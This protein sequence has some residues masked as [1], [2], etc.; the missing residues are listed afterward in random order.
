M[1]DL[2]RVIGIWVENRE[3]YPNTV[4][5][6][7]QAVLAAQNENAPEVFG[8]KS[9]PKPPEFRKAYPE[10]PLEEDLTEQRDIIIERVARPLGLNIDNTL[11]ELSFEFPQRGSFYDNE[12]Y[13]LTVPIIVPQF[14][15]ASFLDMA[16]AA[17][18][19]VSDYLRKQIL[20]GEVKA[21]ED[22]RGVRISN[23]SH[24]IWVQDGTQWV[25][26]KPR[27]V[28]TELQI[29]ENK[30]LIPG[31]LIRGFALSL[32]RWDMV[33]DKGWDLIGDS[34]GPGG[35]PYVHGW[36]DRPE[37]VADPDGHADPYFRAFV[38]GS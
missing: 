1:Q 9:T 3:Q 24:G 13:H 32:L 37:F 4:G 34:V 26:R 6:L 25:N 36:G 5:F 12:G 21:W 27:D 15:D 14:R 38:C 2:E 33:K 17:G 16:D 31:G 20:A 19:Y 28:R 10:R 11:E 7:E 29:E 35:V 8:Q 22:P 30:D 23:R 18:F